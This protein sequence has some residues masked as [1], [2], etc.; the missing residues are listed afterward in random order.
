MKLFLISQDENTSY[1]TYSDAIVAADTEDEARKIHP[2]K[3][4][5]NPNWF[6]RDDSYRYKNAWCDPKEVHVELLSNS[7]YRTE[8]GLILGS[9]QF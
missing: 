4:V 2:S 9:F 5:T 1:D 8:T 3:Y 6:N 7:S